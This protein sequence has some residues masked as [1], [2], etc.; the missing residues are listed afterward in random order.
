MNR[1]KDY[2]GFAIRFTGVGYIALWPL[3]SPSPNGDLFGAPLICRDGSFALVD[4]LCH[5]PHPLQLSISL[6]AVGF[7]AAL[8]VI[9]QFSLRTILRA[10]RKRARTTVNASTLAARLPAKVLRPRRQK[11]IGP[12][13]PVKPRAQFG[14]RGMPH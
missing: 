13:H 7:L 11:P 1:I 14:L 2:T 9:T 5:S 3:S 4:F 12:Q 6:H 8:F 10:R